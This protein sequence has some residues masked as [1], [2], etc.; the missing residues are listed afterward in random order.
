[1]SKS[2]M[3]EREKSYIEK[4]NKFQLKH[5]YKKVGFI[6]S[7]T[8]FGLMIVKKFF[9][10]PDWVKPFLSGV[11]LVG[12]LFI[13]LAKEKIE[14][15][16]IDSLRSQSY[17]IAFVLVILYALIQPFINYGVGLL[18]DEKE[19]LES[20]NYFQILFYMLIVQLMVFWQLKKLNK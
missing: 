2:S 5:Q 20:L 8:A 11:L 4:M 6:I 7:F 17:R 9:D 16:F 1:M 18:F 10:E 3:C 14:D 15:E 12:L 19:T 13:S